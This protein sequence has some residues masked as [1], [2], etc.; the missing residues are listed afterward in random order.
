MNEIRALLLS[1]GK[2]VRLKPL[3]DV[4]TKC[5]MPIGE[6]P[7]LE[8]W[9]EI[10][11]KS[12][13]KKVLVNLHHHPD[14]MRS[15]L[16]R[17]RFSEWVDH[18]FEPQLL[19]TAGTLY[20]NLDFFNGKTTLIIHADNWCQCNFIDFINYHRN[21]RPKSCPIT[22]MTFESTTPHTCGIVETDKNGIVKAFHEK[23]R[24]PPGFIANGAVYLIEPEVLNWIKFNPQIKDLS[25]EV[26][27]HFIGRIATWHNYEIHR[28]IGSI[29][30]LK[31]AQSD[32]KPEPYWSTRDK[33]QDE[34]KTNP[35]QQLIKS[36]KK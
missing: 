23:V 25:S 6:R 4:W 26:L 8:Y 2:G 11:H 5:L 19:G 28:D 3:T 30:S 7:L 29:T 35:I 31:L 34:F 14:S 10:L 16:K 33:W 27:P 21:R 15:F 36:S 32:P 12:G 9:L 13:I 24:N 1:A 18:V 20:S 17:P 22:M